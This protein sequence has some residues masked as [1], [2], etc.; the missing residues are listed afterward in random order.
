MEIKVGEYVRTKD[1]VIAKLDYIEEEYYFDNYI[2]REFEDDINYLDAEQLPEYIIKHSSNIMDLIEVG[3]I[4]KVKEL[5]GIREVIED[6]FFN[7][8]I[9]DNDVRAIMDDT[10]Y[11]SYSKQIKDY[12]IISVVTHEQFAEMEYKV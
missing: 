7:K 8:D 2:Y 11:E 12:K 3:D 6:D 1:G 4:I 9:F 10:F 5:D